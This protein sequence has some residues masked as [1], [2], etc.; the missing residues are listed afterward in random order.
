MTGQA[1]PGL[2]DMEDMTMKKV[3]LFALLG[4]FLLAGLF[5]PNLHAASSQV[6]SH[7]Q[8]GSLHVIKIVWTAAANGSYTSYLIRR[9]INGTLYM[10]ET[11][12][13]ATAPTDDYTVTLTNEASIDVMGG[14]MADCDT[15]GSETWQPYFSASASYG[16]RPVIGR[17][18]LAISDNSQNAAT[19]TIYIYYYAK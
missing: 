19:G 2:H 6:E 14:A 17:L 8:V 5:A 1:S 16:A 11:D 13:G 9:P 10:V 3:F 18:T 12:P 4:A 15:S 7:N